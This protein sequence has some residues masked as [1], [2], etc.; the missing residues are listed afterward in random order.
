MY[1]SCDIVVSFHFSSLFFFIFFRC[2]VT[3]CTVHSNYIPPTH[4]YYY[5]PLLSFVAVP[6]ILSVGLLFVLLISF[7]A[8]PTHH[9]KKGNF[10]FVLKFIISPIHPSQVFSPRLYYEYIM[11]VKRK[12]MDHNNHLAASI[13]TCTKLHIVT[14][15][16][17]GKI[18][19]KFCIGFIGIFFRIAMAHRINKTFPFIRK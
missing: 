4:L 19:H 12:H 3:L 9:T 1:L 17:I 5:A 10:I 13:Q 11:K 16:Y 2:C 8:F 18:L 15:L 7:L 6:P 14:L